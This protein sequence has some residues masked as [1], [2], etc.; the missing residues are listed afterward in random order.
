MKR[1]LIHL[2]PLFLTVGLTGCVGLD[3]T[4]G[5]SGGSGGNTES[6]TTSDITSS[7][8]TISQD[9]TPDSLETN[10]G[11]S[12]RLVKNQEQGGDPCANSQDL[13]DCQPVLLRLYLDMAQTFVDMTR[14]VVSELGTALGDIPDGSQGTETVEGETIHY[15]KESA[16]N[17][18]ILMEGAEPIAYFNIAD[19]V[20]T[21]Q[22]DLDSLEEA[23]DAG[24]KLE[25][26]VDY[27]SE[28]SWSIV[29]FILGMDC[30]S[31][32][33]RAPERIHIRVARS[34]NLWTGKAMFYSGRWLSQTASCSVEESD[35]N[36]MSFYTD[37]VASDIAAKAS[38]YMLSRSKTSLSDIEN[39]GMDQFSI[40]FSGQDDDTS[41]YSNPFCNPASTLDALWNNDC[42][43]IDS[44][45]SS[46]SYGPA[47]DWIVPNTF[48]QETIE[49]PSSL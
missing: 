38:V 35:G 44:S 30:D 19:T 36:S 31:S 4:R 1:F 11:T 7:L 23:G 2:I 25:I 22:M 47:S 13:Y 3:S 28:N 10:S 43:S 41:A 45:V 21:L 34:S 39:F 40:N 48:Y 24:G 27:E 33:P 20:Y 17:F 14:D 37:F 5:S 15:S 32:D 29:I 9:F 16:S 26:V 49:L 8:D 6:S 42:S 12:S 18:S 46:A